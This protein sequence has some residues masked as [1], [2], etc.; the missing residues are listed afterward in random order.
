MRVIA[1]RQLNGDYGLKNPG[2]IIDN[3]PPHLEKDYLARGVV[4]PAEDPKVLYETK[5]ISPEAPEVSAREPFRN[6]PV[7]DEESTDMVAEGDSVLSESDV[8]EEGTADS[9]RR[10]RRK[11]SAAG[12]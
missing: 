5:V 11:G 1:N 4:S 2:D 3:L 7:P 9:R 6:V 8:Q 12:E 10:G